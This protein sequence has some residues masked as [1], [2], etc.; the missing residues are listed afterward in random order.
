MENR[1]ANKPSERSLLEEIE[2]LHSGDIE[3]G[4]LPKPTKIYDISEEEDTP[5]P[6]PKQPVF[7]DTSPDSLLLRK[8]LDEALATRKIAEE[9]LTGYRE[10]IEKLIHERLLF[11]ETSNKKLEEELSLLRLRA[12]EL[13][14][15]KALLEEQ[16]NS[17]LEPLAAAKA[18]LEEEFAR[19]RRSAES[20]LSEKNKELHSLSLALEEAKKDLSSRSQL[21]AAQE[22]VLDGISSS[23][24]SLKSPAR[25]L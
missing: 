23:I 8:E 11:L 2:L 1:M 4:R 3:A 17:Q 7:K 15:Q 22:K 24:L 6:P 18:R 5:P 16:K 21:L 9:K 20:V 10:G 14:K 19:F 25:S 13:E 12:Q